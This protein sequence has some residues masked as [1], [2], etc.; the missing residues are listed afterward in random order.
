MSDLRPKPYKIKLGG[1]EF[2]LL[3]SLNSIDEIQDHFNIS[4]S[5]LTELMNDERSVFKNL[6]YL[7]TV[8][9]NEAIDD[10][11]DGFSSTESKEQR[12]HVDERWVGRKI[13]TNNF[14]QLTNDILRAFAEG[15]PESEEED[16]NEKSE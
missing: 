1:Q 2:G 6:R 9:I 3:F 11:N 15:S 10:E 4:I 12:L 14:K 13:S 7:L 5:Q 16:P 8:L